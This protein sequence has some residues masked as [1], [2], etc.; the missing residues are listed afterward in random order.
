MHENSWTTEFLC[1]NTLSCLACKVSWTHALRT[2]VKNCYKHHAREDLLPE[3]SEDK[4]KDQ[5]LQ[6][7]SLLPT[8]TVVQTVANDDGT[9]SLIQVDTGNTVATLTDVTVSTQ[10]CHAHFYPSK[11]VTV[12]ILNLCVYKLGH[13]LML[14]LTFAIMYPCKWFP[15][16]A[17]F[18]SL[19]LHLMIAKE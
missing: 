3:F 9:F 6:H 13:T 19:K 14:V 16:T 7:T 10:C 2:I 5:Q 4:D 1:P 11:V 18:L 17:T 12:S 15:E 8:H